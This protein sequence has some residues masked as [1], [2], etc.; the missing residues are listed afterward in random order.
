MKTLSFFF[1]L[2][3]QVSLLAVVNLGDE[4]IG[5]SEMGMWRKQAEGS[6]YNNYGGEPSYSST[7]YYYNEYIPTRLDSSATGSATGS[8]NGG[9][10]SRY[11]YNSYPE[12]EETI[13]E[14][15]SFA[16]Y[17]PVL[18]LYKTT[19]IRYNNSGYK[20]E[21]IEV[22]NGQTNRIVYDYDDSDNLISE[23]EYSS[24][25]SQSDPLR[26]TTHDYDPQNRLIYTEWTSQ[27]TVI[28]NRW[29]SWSN[30]AL[31]DSIYLYQPTTYPAIIITEHAFDENEILYYKS[32]IQKQTASSTF[33]SRN[34]YHYTYINADEMLF[35]S[36]TLIESCSNYSLEVPFTPTSTQTIIY[37][38]SNNYHSV[39]FYYIGNTSYN[40]DDN[41]LLTNY[42]NANDDGIRN[43]SITWQYYGP[44]SNQDWLAPAPVLLSYPNPAKDYMTVKLKQPANLLSRNAR[45]FNIRGQ[46]VRNL[47]SQEM[48]GNDLIYSWDCRDENRLP[49]PSGIYLIKLETPSG[50]IT[51]RVSVV[52]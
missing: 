4:Y 8:Y 34:D 25:Y 38:Y 2:I 20:I 9:S 49:V 5:L 1:L 10:V 28:A 41:W 47:S 7:T 36:Q 44:L 40:Y 27:N 43:E 22:W 12:Y 39:A 32:T 15:W 17:D 48:S 52:K 11:F 31:P 21:E 18:S 19:T 6:S 29:Q 30:H 51:R 35:P 33:W 46:L 14:V 23:T 24:T 42:H 45:I 3:I 26:I 13:V 16:F 50:S 37:N